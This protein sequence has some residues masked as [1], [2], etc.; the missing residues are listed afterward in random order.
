MNYA[1]MPWYREIKTKKG[2]EDYDELDSDSTSNNHYSLKNPKVR[3][4]SY[5]ELSKTTQRAVKRACNR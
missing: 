4:D 1:E 2:T 3:S 5:H